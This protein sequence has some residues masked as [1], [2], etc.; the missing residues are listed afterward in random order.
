MEFYKTTLRGSE[1]NVIFTGSH[2]FF[3]NSYYGVI[4]IAERDY[5]ETDC[6][7]ERAKTFFTLSIGNSH[8]QGGSFSNGAV[9]CFVRRFIRKAEQECKPTN[10]EFVTRDLDLN[11]GCLVCEFKPY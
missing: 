5:D 2:Y 3:H 8:C 11:K 6:S 4:A 9:E 7:G 1:V 10:V